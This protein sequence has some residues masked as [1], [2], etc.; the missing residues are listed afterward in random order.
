MAKDEPVGAAQQE[1]VANDCTSGERGKDQRTEPWL[2]EVAGEENH[3][4]LQKEAS[5]TAALLNLILRSRLSEKTSFDSHV[6]D[7][8]R[9]FSI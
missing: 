9:K 5:F 7:E 8:I 2:A 1:S 4:S 6:F 3:R